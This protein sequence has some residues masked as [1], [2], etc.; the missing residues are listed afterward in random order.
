MANKSI[1]EPHD[2][3]EVRFSLLKQ[4]VVVISHN[5]SLIMVALSN[6]LGIFG[7]YG[8]SVV[9]DKPEGRLGDW[10]ETKNKTKNNPKK[11]NL[12]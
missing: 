1:N 11:I 8:G 3:L 6:K 5:V 4:E 9:G 10:E 12:V 2:P 7:E